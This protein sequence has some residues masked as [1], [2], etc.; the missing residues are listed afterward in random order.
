MS[1]MGSVR[2]SVRPSVAEKGTSSPFLLAA[3]LFP[4]GRPPGRSQIRFADE[5][6]RQRRAKQASE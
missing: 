2:P 6:N 1:G 4:S 3:Q 5:A